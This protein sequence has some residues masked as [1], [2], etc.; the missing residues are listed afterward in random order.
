[1][2]ARGSHVGARV[3]RAATKE[4]ISYKMEPRVILQ[5]NYSPMP[6]PGLAA[7]GPGGVCEDAGF[8]VVVGVV[9]VFGAGVMGSSKALAAWYWL[10]GC[11]G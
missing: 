2:L 5:R 6:A 11:C 7:G 10:V 9:L 1:M 4:A 8:G 3:P